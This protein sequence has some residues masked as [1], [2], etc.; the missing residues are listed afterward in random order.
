M[1]EPIYSLIWVWNQASSPIQ[2]FS[3]SGTLTLNFKHDHLTHPK[4]DIVVD[5][6]WSRTLQLN[7]EPK[8]NKLLENCLWQRE[9]AKFGRWDHLG[10]QTTVLQI[11][12]HEN[13]DK[14][15]TKEI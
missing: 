7:I 10:A 2:L 13:G 14:F 3:A 6:I 4:I 9:P 11:K 15:D 5:P 12:D 1:N 8:L